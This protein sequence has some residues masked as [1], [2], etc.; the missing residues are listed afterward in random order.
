M[1]S[2]HR[3]LQETIREA[4]LLVSSPSLGTPETVRSLLKL[5]EAAVDAGEGDVPNEVVLAAQLHWTSLERL[6]LDHP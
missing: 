5:A 2:A 4:N 3:V 6:G 1:A